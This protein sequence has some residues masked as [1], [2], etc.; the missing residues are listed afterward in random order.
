MAT[1]RYS[2]LNTVV[3][4]RT[5][6]KRIYPAQNANPEDECPTLRHDPITRASAARQS[7]LFQCLDFAGCSSVSRTMCQFSKPLDMTMQ[8]SSV[9]HG[10]MVLKQ[11]ERT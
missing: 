6:P 1:T 7:E 5:Q 10:D 3:P 2:T 8:L 4:P 9:P 11:G